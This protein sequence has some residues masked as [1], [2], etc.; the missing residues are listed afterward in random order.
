MI[1]YTFVFFFEGHL[2]IDS[3]CIKNNVSYIFI[4]KQI[5]ILFDTK[6]NG[7]YLYSWSDNITMT[8]SVIYNNNPKVRETTISIRMIFCSN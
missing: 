5:Y 4:L 8:D 6:I 3:I 2:L 1:L 7:T